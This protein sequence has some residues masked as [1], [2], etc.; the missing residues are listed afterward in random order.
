[1]LLSPKLLYALARMGHGDEIG[2]PVGDRAS[3]TP[4]SWAE[5]WRD[6]RTPTLPTPNPA[7]LLAPQGSRLRLCPGRRRLPM[8]GKSRVLR[9]RH[10]FGRPIPPRN[11]TPPATAF[12]R[13]LR[14]GRA[15]QAP[16]QALVS[17]K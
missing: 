13:K 14:P 15:T 3:G 17:P 1:M 2:E 12:F 4:T 5:V 7:P 9:W 16:A 11:R 10:C 6:M 8:P